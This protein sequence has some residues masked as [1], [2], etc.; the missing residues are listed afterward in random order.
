MDEF[1]GAYPEACPLL[2]RFSFR[3]SAACCAVETG[4][5]R[6][7][8]LSTF[9]SPIVFLLVGSDELT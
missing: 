4:L 7:E 9:P 2:L 3:S 8:V 6:S 1:N 5:L